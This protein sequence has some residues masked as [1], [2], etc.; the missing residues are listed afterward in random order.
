[1][2][3]PQDIYDYVVKNGKESDFLSAILL[4][5]DNYSIAEIAD[6]V[7]SQDD[8]GCRLRSQQYRLNLPIVDEQ[9]G[10]AVRSG[11]YLSA[12]ISRQEDQYQLHFLV[13]RCQADQKS[14]FEEEI[15][16]AVVRY[17]ILKTIVALRLTTWRKVDEY[18]EKG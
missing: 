9:I 14:Q 6:A 5:K 8:T 7:F 1:M 3:T 15:A 4:Q 16:R 18:L 17:L 10:A 11:R 13:H 2:N 12:F